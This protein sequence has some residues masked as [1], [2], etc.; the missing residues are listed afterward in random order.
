MQSNCSSYILAGHDQSHENSMKQK[1][2]VDPNY[3]FMAASQ[4]VNARISQRLQALAL[5]VTL[6]VGL[7]AA[8]VALKPGEN[9]S[10]LPIEWMVLG[11]PV[12]SIC[13]AFLDY[14]A[15]RAISNLRKFLSELEKLHDA[16]AVLPSYN[17]DPKWAIGA[18]RARRFH[19]YAAA[20]LVAGGNAIGL[21]AVLKIYPERMAEN[22]EIVWISGVI[23]ICAFV[24]LLLI[25]RWSYQPAA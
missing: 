3:R 6:I 7:L 4:E 12:S 15:E 1:P 16:H 25:P 19:D 23:A 20:M 21:G 10:K 18:N 17:T 24:A 5:Y 14:K 11:F 8:F 22:S 9:T 13:L 2:I